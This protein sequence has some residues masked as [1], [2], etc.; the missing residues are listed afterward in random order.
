MLCAPLL[1]PLASGPIRCWTLSIQ[2]LLLLSF[3]ICTA[4]AWV[5]LPSPLT[6]NILIGISWVSLALAAHPSNPSF[7]LFLARSPYGE[8]SLRQ[9]LLTA[10]SSWVT[11]AQTSV[12]TLIFIE[13]SVQMPRLDILRYLS[14]IRPLSS[15][16]SPLH[17]H[18]Q[19]A[20]S[21]LSFCPPYS[22][23]GEHTALFQ[24]P[25]LGSC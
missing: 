4:P 14:I 16:Q 24:P 8:V 20:H 9:G 22:A 10:S 15:K 6:W 21:L 11:T 18:Q 5:K 2:P 7:V 19:S 23:L 13:N 17:V 12:M 1:T 3:S 25:W